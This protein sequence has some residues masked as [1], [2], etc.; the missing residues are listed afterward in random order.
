MKGRSERRK[1]E[2]TRQIRL[3]GGRRY[4]WKEK[5]EDGR[6]EGMM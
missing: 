1:E 6:M 2:E 4:V 5:R 3:G